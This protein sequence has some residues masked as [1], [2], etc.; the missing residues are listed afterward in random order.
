MSKLVD[1]DRSETTVIGDVVVMSVSAVPSVSFTN[2]SFE[3]GLILEMVANPKAFPGVESVILL[4]D[5]VVHLLPHVCDNLG[6]SFVVLMNI[7]SLK[8]VVDMVVVV[9]AEGIETVLADMITGSVAMPGADRVAVVVVAR[10]V[11]SEASISQVAFIRTDIALEEVLKVSGN[12]DSINS[13]KV[14]NLC[15]FGLVVIMDGNFSL[16]KGP[17]ITVFSEGM[18]QGRSVEISLLVKY[19]KVQLS[20]THDGVVDLL[21]D[22]N[23][24]LGKLVGTSSQALGA[25][26]NK[27][28]MVILE[29]SNLQGNSGVVLGDDVIQC[30]VKLST[31]FSDLFISFFDVVNSSDKA[32]FASVGV[33]SVHVLLEVILVLGMDGLQVADPSVSLGIHFAGHFSKSSIQEILDFSHNIGRRSFFPSFRSTVIAGVNLQDFSIV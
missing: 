18:L 10:L 27:L 15:P 17:P 5:N 22:V 11:E 12:L 14:F 1:V 3:C 25:G 8:N 31:V 29:Q 24:V 23:A 19:G 13:D 6:S 20:E 26:Y 21:G 32:V 2:N 9:E 30:F 33:E 4:A 16:N 7:A 28:S